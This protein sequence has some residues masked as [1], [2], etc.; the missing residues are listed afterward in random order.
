MNFVEKAEHVGVLRSSSGNLPHI[1]NRIACHKRALA[2]VLPVGLARGHRGN[3]AASIIISNI[4]ATPVLFSGLSSLVLKTTET[5]LLNQ[6][7][8]ETTQRLLKLMERSPACVVA[9][10][11]GQLPGIAILHI[12]QL[13]LFGMV[14]RLP[15]NVLNKHAHNILTS[16]KS[17]A[18]SW[19]QQ[20]HD[21][22]IK[23]RLPQTCKKWCSLT[24]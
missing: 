3:P 16:A 7:L 15:G 13:A 23:Y 14:A 24:A 18:S 22:C 10:L 19:F 21:L 6:Y 1:S 20:I 17:S 4:Y 5:A 9:F 2:A 12:K 11:A 8:K